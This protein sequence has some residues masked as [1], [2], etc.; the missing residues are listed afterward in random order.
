MVSAR[1]LAKEYGISKSSAHRILVKDLGPHA[2]KMTI[3]PK[4]T[5]EQKNKR[6]IFVHWVGNRGA[7]S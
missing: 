4:L 1:R 2:Y 6:K 5:G 3:E 7:K